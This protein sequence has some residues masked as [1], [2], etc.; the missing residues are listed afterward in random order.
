MKRI[1]PIIISIFA[2]SISN[3]IGQTH[4]TTSE[5]YI[6]SFIT[7]MYNDKLYEDY[8]FLQKHCSPELLKK[9]QDAQRKKPSRK[10][11]GFLWEQRES[12]PRPSA[13]KAD[14]LNQLSYA[15]FSCFFC[16]M[17]ALDF[18]RRSV[19]TER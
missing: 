13:C 15:P 3:A 1:V 6:K 7:K 4:D 14:A 2:L 8:D 9:L 17:A 16:P 5:D 12:N 19:I 10:L 11:K 18:I